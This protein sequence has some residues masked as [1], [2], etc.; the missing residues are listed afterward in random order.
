MMQNDKK[1]VIRVRAIIFHQNR[2][3]VVKH[4][5]NL[6]YYALPGGMLDFGEDIQECLRRELV[7]ELGLVAQVG[8]LLYV[9]NFVNQ[10]GIQSIEFFFEIKNSGDFM[11]I[12]SLKGSHRH[13]IAEIKWITTDES[14]ATKPKQLEEDFKQGKILSDVVRIIYHN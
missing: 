5:H 9:N 3:L 14:L 4:P 12:S 1:V 6:S 8:R 2:L 10:E 11:D 13:E 7:E